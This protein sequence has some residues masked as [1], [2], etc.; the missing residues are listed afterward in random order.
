MSHFVQPI[1]P[2][3]I[4]PPTVLGVFRLFFTTA[5]MATIVEETNR[6]AQQ[7]LGDA[8]DGKWVDIDADEMWAFLGF[9]LLMGINKLLQMHQYWCRDPVFHYLPIAGRIPRD[10]FFAIW[11]FYISPQTHQ[12]LLQ[13]ARHPPRHRLPHQVPHVPLTDSGRSGQ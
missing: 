13:H 12:H 7:V 1:G 6:Y 5:L 9:V 3:V 10:R 8:A 4:L 2:A 11:R